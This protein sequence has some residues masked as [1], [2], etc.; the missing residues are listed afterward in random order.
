[1]IKQTEPKASGEKETTLELDP[2]ADSGEIV[3]EV[4]AALQALGEYDPAISALL[5]SSQSKATLDAISMVAISIAEERHLAGTL[6]ARQLREYES[7]VEGGA[8]LMFELMKN[9]QTHRHKMEMGMLDVRKEELTATLNNQATDLTVR[10]NSLH[11]IEQRERRGQNIGGALAFGVLVLGGYLI[12]LGHPEIGAGMIGS[13]MVAI[14]AV[15]V[16]RRR[17]KKPGQ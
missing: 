4:S 15:F 14:A 8:H 12:H 5:N 2:A 11:L 17:P 6:S 7:V 13:T 16:T 3:E 9:E 1:M 10:S